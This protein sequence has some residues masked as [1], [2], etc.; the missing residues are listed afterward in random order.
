[1]M[2]R[3]GWRRVG[4]LPAGDGETE[5]RK[6][7]E[8]GRTTGGVCAGDSGN[9]QPDVRA[10]WGVMCREMERSRPDAPGES[11]HGVEAS[12]GGS[13][14]AKKLRSSVFTASERSMWLSAMLMDC[15][16]SAFRDPDS[17]FCFRPPA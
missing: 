4:G 15:L 12:S 5:G 3:G 17:A 6:D 2:S 9:W 16:C 13:V 10:G 1:M 11:A 14:A 8:I 7:G